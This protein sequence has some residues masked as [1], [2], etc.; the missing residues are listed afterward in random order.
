MD[1]NKKTNLIRLFAF[2][3][4]A[5]G[6]GFILALLSVIYYVWI[7]HPI[8]IMEML[9]VTITFFAFIYFRME[10]KKL[11]ATDSDK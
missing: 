8:G 11:R 3:V 4:W 7:G 10:L 2:G 9:N 1:N 5:G 6:I